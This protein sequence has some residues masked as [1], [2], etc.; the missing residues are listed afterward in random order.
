MKRKEIVMK[1]DF[2]NLPPVEK[3]KIASSAEIDP[4]MAT[5]KTTISA[6]RAAQKYKLKGLQL[7]DKK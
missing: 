3:Q 2:S 4:K 1:N 5:S 6:L 7:G